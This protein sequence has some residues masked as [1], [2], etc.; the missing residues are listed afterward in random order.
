MTT[1]QEKFW[2]I[3]KNVESGNMTSE[4]GLESI[5]GINFLDFSLDEMETVENCEWLPAS[6]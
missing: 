1:E 5:K 3:S 4:Q 2:E 6:F